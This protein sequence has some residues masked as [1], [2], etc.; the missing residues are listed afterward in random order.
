M[1]NVKNLLLIVGGS[2]KGD[3]F[4]YLAPLMRKRVRALVCI[5]AT[6]DQ[7]IALAEQEHLPYLSTDDLWKGVE[8]LY[9]Q[10]R[11]W[12]VL[13]LSPGCASFWLF[14]DYLDRANQ[15]RECIKK[16]S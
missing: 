7:F 9:M 4:D 16:L 8:W 12:D 2:D 10:W 14:R 15:F 6:K 13:M 3:M 5:G 1:N 11:R